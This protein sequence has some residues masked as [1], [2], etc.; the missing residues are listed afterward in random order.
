MGGR[1]DVRML[2]FSYMPMH[3]YK[4][5]SR[6]GIITQVLSFCRKL[7]EAELYLTNASVSP[8]SQ[9]QYLY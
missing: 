8:V 4:K 6:R 5:K 9:V 2:I 3:I 7:L 1:Q